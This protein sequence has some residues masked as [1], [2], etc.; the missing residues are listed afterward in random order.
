MDSTRG[1]ALKTWNRIW[2][3]FEGPGPGPD[4]CFDP[5]YV[6][7]VRCMGMCTDPGLGVW[8]HIR[9]RPI[10]R[11]WAC[12][13]LGAWALHG[14]L[15]Y[16]RAW[17]LGPGYGL[18]LDLGCIRATGLGLYMGLYPCIQ[19]YIPCIQACTRGLPTYPG[20]RGMGLYP[21]AYPCIH[22][23]YRP[24]HG[25]VHTPCAGLDPGYAHTLDLG[26]QPWI[27]ALSRYGSPG[28]AT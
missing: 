23:V 28:P 1:F 5:K 14:D 20:S 7:R 16:I 9:Y 22:R 18:P 19:A 10:S 3:Y 6:E 13:G 8:A 26:L 11:I 12:T 25:Y 4:P 15:G 24:V 2:A 27:W 21:C 17:A